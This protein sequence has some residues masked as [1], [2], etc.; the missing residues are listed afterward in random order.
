MPR[1]ILATGR[2]MRRAMQRPYILHNS[3]LYVCEA[4]RKQCRLAW[5]LPRVYYERGPL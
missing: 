3:I 2:I 5:Q 1:K 4:Y